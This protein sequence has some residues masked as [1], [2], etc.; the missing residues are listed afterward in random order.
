MKRAECN[1]TTL[2]ETKQLF[3]AK[4]QRQAKPT[5]KRS[6]SG[7]HVETLQ[8]PKPPEDSQPLK[9][10]IDIH[11]PSTTK[12]QKRRRSGG[13]LGLHHV[14]ILVLLLSLPRGKYEVSNFRDNNP[15]LHT[16][17]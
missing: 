1:R 8:I 7:V 3:A 10:H 4:I 14:S 15:T 6:A 2:E 17:R 11:S 12:A 9:P 5:S 13:S 16:V